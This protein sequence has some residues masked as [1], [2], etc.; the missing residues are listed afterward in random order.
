[1]CCVLRGFEFLI[2]GGVEREGERERE[3]VVKA[4]GFS[5]GVSE[6]DGKIS[7]YNKTS[8]VNFGEVTL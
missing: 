8:V 3:V 5:F 1:M 4:F 6:K 2:V 7:W